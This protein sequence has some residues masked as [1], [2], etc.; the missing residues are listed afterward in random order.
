L[1]ALSELNSSQLK[2]TAPPENIFTSPGSF[3]FLLDNNGVFLDN[4]DLFLNNNSSIFIR[5]C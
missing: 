1:A 5:Y 3:E 2:F 4:Y